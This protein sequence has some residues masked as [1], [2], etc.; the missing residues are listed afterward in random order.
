MI[1]NL[2]GRRTI[3]LLTTSMRLIIIGDYNQHQEITRPLNLKMY[4]K[5]GRLEMFLRL[6]ESLSV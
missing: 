2:S 1:M 5:E 3:T 4:S 6:E